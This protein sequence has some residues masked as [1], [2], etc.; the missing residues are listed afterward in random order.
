MSSILGWNNCTNSDC[1][2]KLGNTTQIDTHTQ[3][4]NFCHSQMNIEW[5]FEAIHTS[6][7]QHSTKRSPSGKLGANWGVRK[8]WPITKTFAIV[9]VA[10]VG[11]GRQT[12]R[13]KLQM[14]WKKPRKDRGRQGEGEME[15]ERE[16]EGDLELIRQPNYYY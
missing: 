14:S 16:R 12:D 7:A 15:I 5:I 13:Q 6:T 8:L 1:I 4:N 10:V 3:S 11:I 2:G 9:A